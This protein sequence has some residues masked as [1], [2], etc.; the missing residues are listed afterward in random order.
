[1]R[2]GWHGPHDRL[3]SSRSQLQEPGIEEGQTYTINFRYECE[4]IA[5]NVNGTPV[6]GSPFTDGSP[7]LASGR[8]G[9]GDN[10]FG[11]PPA[12]TK[13]WNG[14]ALPQP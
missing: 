6:G 7:P 4:Q 9:V 10:W 11:R 14:E 13:A 3:L 1:M 5:V 2:F 12:A 8:V